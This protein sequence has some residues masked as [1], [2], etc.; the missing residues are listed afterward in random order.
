MIEKSERPKKRILLEVLQTYNIG[1][2]LTTHQVAERTGLSAREVAA[3]LTHNKRAWGIERLEVWRVAR[4]PSEER[5]VPLSQDPLAEENLR[6]VIEQYPIGSQFTIFN[7]SE[8]VGYTPRSISGY[9][10]YAKYFY[11]SMPESREF[12]SY[13]KRIE[14]LERL[15]IEERTL[16]TRERTINVYVRVK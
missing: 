1:D 16:H 2:I 14:K 13:L 9:L 7:L 12:K 10:A 11:N 15:G 3:L 5:K 4:E 8:A 6:G